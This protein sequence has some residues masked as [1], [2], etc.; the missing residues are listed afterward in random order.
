MAL[1]FGS[2]SFVMSGKVHLCRIADPPE[3][4]GANE[5]NREVVGPK[6]YTPTQRL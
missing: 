4:R 2:E 3:A 6:Y 5:A 1:D